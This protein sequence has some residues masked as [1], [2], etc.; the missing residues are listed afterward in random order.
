MNEMDSNDSINPLSALLDAWE[1]LPNDLRGDPEL[2][3]VSKWIELL[4]DGVEGQWYDAGEKSA[5]YK[6]RDAHTVW[7]DRIQQ[8][9]RPAWHKQWATIQMLRDNLFNKG[10]EFEINDQ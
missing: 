6:V 3:Q 1:Q 9:G 2:E 5:Y 8:E 7:M 10:G 4:I